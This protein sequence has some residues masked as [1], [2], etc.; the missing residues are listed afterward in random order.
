MKL[1]GKVSGNW[2]TSSGWCIDANGLEVQR[3]VTLSGVSEEDCFRIC[4]GNPSLSGCSYMAY[5]G[6]C[7][8][9]SGY[10]VGG[11]GHGSYK[12]HYRRSKCQLRL[13]SFRSLNMFIL[14]EFDYAYIWIK[15]VKTAECF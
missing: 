14:L 5:Y 9:Y 11:N 2:V 1:L 4:E 8:T 10:I 15:I 7:V 12:C 13:K 3:N 6:A